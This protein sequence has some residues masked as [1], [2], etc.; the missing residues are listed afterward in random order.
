MTLVFKDALFDAQ[1]LRT[2]G[3]SSS[4]GADIGE[5]YAVA[6]RIAGAD[7]ESWHLAWSSLAERLQAEAE[8]SLAAGCRASAFAGF[9]RASNYFRAAYTFLI[10]TPVDPRVVEGYRRQRSSF[11]AAAALMAPKAERIAIPYGGK[12]LHGYF[13]RAAGG[14]PRPTLIVNGGYDSTAEE[15]YFFSGAAAMAR[16][17]GCITFDGPG[18]GAAIIEDGLVFRPDWEEV[19]R[20]VV[21]FALRRPEVDPNRIALMGISFGGYLA[22]RAA[23][24]EPRL[25]ACIADPGEF[26]LLE[27]FKSRLPGF[28]ARALPDGNPLILNLLDL[29]LRRRMKHVSAGWGLR[30]GLWVHGVDSPLAYIRLTRDYALEGRAE[31]IR[32]P[33]LVCAAEN[34]DIGVTAPKLYEV[35]TCPKRFIAFRA[36]EGAGEHCEAGARTLFNQRAFDWLDGVFSD[37][38]PPRE[39]ELPARAGRNAETSRLQQAT[40]TTT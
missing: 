35:L 8:A 21:D 18:Q 1:W 38:Q 10:G 24:G 20:P 40:N 3:H 22:P 5:C 37:R 29:I 36:E 31:L 32:C 7:P 26:S 17:Y 11:G 27:E 28:I 13:F 19:I 6:G 12:S 9:L 15:A 33:T 25:A 14:G 23:S 30:R 34:D 2:A 39:G 4:G 16:G